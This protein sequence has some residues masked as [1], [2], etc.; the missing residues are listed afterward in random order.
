[1]TNIQVAYAEHIENARHQVETEREA[2]RHNV[3]SEAETSKHNRATEKEARKVRKET[4]RSNKAQEKLKKQQNDET[5]RHNLVTEGQGQQSLDE[6]A[7][8]NRNTEALS[9]SVAELQAN[10]RIVAAQI[11]AASAQQIASL[12]ASVN[13][14]IAE[15]N[16]YQKKLDR[17]ASLAKNSQSSATQKQIN[18]AK[19]AADKYI[20]SANLLQK[21]I[22]DSN[23]K[24]VQ[25]QYIE[26]QKQKQQWDKDYQ[27]KKISNEQL[28]T[29]IEGWKALFNNPMMKTAVEAA[30]AA[31]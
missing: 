7:L 18:N 25:Q 1:M 6:Q 19:I 12:N 10:A 8:H 24:A 20:N 13:T 30:A 16:N 14:A 26:L 2:N 22:A 31:K 15:A 5:Q 11:A 29:L 27:D 9:L 21:A 23:W 17:D 3:A 4:K 28:Q